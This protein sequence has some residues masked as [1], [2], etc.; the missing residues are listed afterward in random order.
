ML[1]TVRYCENVRDLGFREYQR[2]IFSGLVPMNQWSLAHE[3]MRLSTQAL[4]T[5]IGENKAGYGN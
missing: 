4:S 5:M 3:H 2:S 1:D